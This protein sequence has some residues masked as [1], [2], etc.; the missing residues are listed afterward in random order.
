VNK[1]FVYIIL[2]IALFVTDKLEAINA[3]IQLGRYKG[4]GLSYLEMTYHISGNSVNFVSKDSLSFFCSVEVTLI[5]MLDEKTV[6]A[7]KF[8]LNSP[9][10][11]TNIDLIDIKRYNLSNGKY[12][13]LVHIVDLNEPENQLNTALNF[14]LDFTGNKLESSD[15][16]LY[17]NVTPSDSYNNQFVRNGYFMEP[18]S[19]NFFPKTNNHLYS[20]WEI[21]SGSNLEGQRIK[22][23]SRI[24]K[25]NKTSDLLPE[26]NHVKTYRAVNILPVLVHKTITKLPSGNYT[27]MLYVRDSN[28]QIILEK[29]VFFQ[30]S[31]P[32]ADANVL[33]VDKEIFSTSFVQRLTP[34]EIRYSLR[35]LAPV[36]KNEDQPI[37]NA[38]IASNNI[39]AGKVYLH[40]YWNSLF[41]NDAEKKYQEYTSMAKEVDRAYA[42]G[43]GYGFET[44]RGRIWL[45]YGP[46]NDKII[47][48]EDPNAP[49][50]EIWA[51]NSFPKT[52]QGIV[53]F[54]FYNPHLNNDYILLH[55]N[56]RIEIQNPRWLKELYKQSK[57][58]ANSNDF[59]ESG[60]IQD[61]PM[62]NARQYFEE[63]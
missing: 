57:S 34:Q 25:N 30:R 43:F 26:Y 27:F 20:Y 7:D 4:P 36:A 22:V 38:T 51:Y 15:I 53:K 16:Q 17:A 50:Y 54:I 6:K 23:E 32:D 13:L 44:D 58:E 14:T 29:K 18:I 1:I 48:D 40:N 12:Q 62:K 55:S 47:V 33:P 19:S 45:R 31:N 41:P 46:P 9:L 8:V 61:G 37:L 42:S 24:Q 59:L 11:K 3:N 39:E 60:N 10:T 49:P 2:S 56:C 35:S 5:F 21:Y 63:L 28:D 52:N